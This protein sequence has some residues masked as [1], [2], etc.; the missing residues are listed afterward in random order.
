MKKRQIN[1]KIDTEAMLMEIL[2]GLE[3]IYNR[4]KKLEEVSIAQ[5][6]KRMEFSKSELSPDYLI[7]S[8]R[9]FEC[10]H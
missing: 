7:D 3:D 8:D 9:W 10:E 4:V 6:A 5:S 1:Q 2:H